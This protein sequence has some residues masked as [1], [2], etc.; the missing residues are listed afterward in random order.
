[1]S[2]ASKTKARKMFPP[3]LHVEDQARMAKGGTA[4]F[5]LME[6]LAAMAVVA[7][8]AALVFPAT[9]GLIDRGQSAKAMSNMR[10]IGV[11]MANYVPENN[12]RLPLLQKVGALGS[13][14]N[15]FAFWQ[16]FIRLQN[17]LTASPAEEN[18]LPKIFYDP[19]LKGRR[20][21]PWGSF[22]ANDAIMLHDAACLAAFGQAEGTPLFRIGTLSRKVIVS[23]AADQPGSRFSS[24]WYFNGDTWVNQGSAS[25]MPKPDARHGG[26]ALSLFGDWHVE[27]LD[28]NKMSTTERKQYYLPDESFF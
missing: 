22:G 14:P 8:L 24:S 12:N 26:K 9:K 10:Q 28:V 18:W 5:S 17:G 27:A 21:H 2:H 15:D 3:D 19:I 20:E 13:S 7:V 25:G 11:L 1:M 23:S 4:G 6:I 16:N